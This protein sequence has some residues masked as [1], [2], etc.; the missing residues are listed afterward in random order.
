M[1]KRLS[2]YQLFLFDLDG[3]LVDTEEMHY[4]AYIAASL[5]HGC[6][7]DLDFPTYFR[8]AQ[9]DAEA[10]KHRISELFTQQNL[11]MPPWDSLYADKKRA[12]IEILKQQ[13]ATL[14]PGAKEL[15][16]ALQERGIKHC[17]VTHSGR[18]LTELIRKQHDVLIRIPYWICR[19]DYD[20]P[21]PSP[22]GYEKAI[23]TLANEHDAI[24]GFE[25]STRGMRALM[26]TRATA[27]LVNS[28]DDSVRVLFCDLGVPVFSTLREV[29]IE[30][31]H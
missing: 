23:H 17:V 24:I 14:L 29:L 22:D 13:P 11:Q 27:V 18:E 5:Q 20:K 15:L 31:M 9:K 3:L 1:M 8:L 4:R 30:Y 26:A 2:D 25:D 21:K 10:I 12:Y 6:V 7:L 19:E 28:I 16:E